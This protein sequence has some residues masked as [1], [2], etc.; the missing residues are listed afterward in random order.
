MEEEVTMC[1]FAHETF[2]GTPYKTEYGYLLYEK[3][4]FF[5]DYSIADT[6]NMPHSMWTRELVDE[7]HKHGAR[8]FAY[9]G[10]GAEETPDL[11]KFL[12]AI[13]IDILCTN[14]PET[15]IDFRASHSP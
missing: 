2:D 7:T 9:I 14:C 8:A 5:I 15:A 6:V 11:Y 10:G 1:T 12:Y 4:P 3:I 13:G